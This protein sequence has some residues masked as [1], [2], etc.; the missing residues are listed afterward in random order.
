MVSLLDDVLRDLSR[1][2]SND[3][4][5]FF[6]DVG[7]YKGICLLCYCSL[8][9]WSIF[10]KTF[11]ILIFPV[12]FGGPILISSAIYFI[13]VRPRLDK[14]Y[15][16]KG[17]ILETG[18]ML[19]HRENITTSDGGN[20][21][22]KIRHEVTVQYSISVSSESKQDMDKKRDNN[23]LYIFTDWDCQESLPDTMDFME[24]VI[25][26]GIPESGR[27]KSSFQKQDSCFCVLYQV[28]FLLMAGWLLFALDAIFW[29]I[30]FG[31]EYYM[32]IISFIMIFFMM[33][34]MYSRKAIILNAQRHQIEQK[35]CA[36]D[37]VGT[38]IMKRDLV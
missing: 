26:P 35:D 16:E 34:R 30:C 4:E 1:Y 33:S 27:L 38:E 32:C 13:H 19:S 14:E 15:R 28:L 20:M 10:L 6:E 17:V 37:T 36:A 25:L 12:I 7:N 23:H 31:D 9:F 29:S 24:V 22:I 2:V 8:R 21:T 3:M 5:S 18:K 11:I